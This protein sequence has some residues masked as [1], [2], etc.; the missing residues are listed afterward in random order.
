MMI[1]INIYMLINT[2]IKNP[3]KILRN[4]KYLIKN[5]FSSNSK[6]FLH[7]FDHGKF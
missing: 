6:P 3:I 5:N 4:T 1:Y 2:M 7:D